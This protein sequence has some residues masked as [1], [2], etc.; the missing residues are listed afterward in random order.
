MGSS[1]D[2]ELIR[3]FLEEL[4][5]RISHPDRLILLGGGALLLL[6]SSRQTLDLDYVGDDLTKNELQQ[7]IDALADEMRVSVEAV[8]FDTFVPVSAAA[9]AR[10]RFIGRFGVLDVYVFD[11]YSI[12][13]SKLDRG[14][15]T[16]IADVA[17]L[18][19]RELVDLAVLQTEL[20]AALTQARA[21]A[22]N[23]EEAQAHLDEL[24]R[25]LNK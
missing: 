15:D 16:D 18:V 12:A 17:F 3:Q 19:Q 1:I 10:H 9:Q 21:F 13:V 22:M 24:R 20:S 5:R 8:P 2:E 23:P 4:G 11:L 14:L 7:V 6:G 25:A